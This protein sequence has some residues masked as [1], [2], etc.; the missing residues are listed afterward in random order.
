MDPEKFSPD[1]GH[2]GNLGANFSLS[3]ACP[4]RER[5]ASCHGR[6][7]EN[8]PGDAENSTGERQAGINR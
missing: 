3:S 1:I 2:P 5:P 4:E 8:P 6:A 7:F